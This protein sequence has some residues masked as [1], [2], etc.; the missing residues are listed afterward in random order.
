MSPAAARR[1]SPGGV[2]SS[3]G[4]PGS[5]RD[6]ALNPP[7]TAAEHIEEKDSDCN[8]QKGVNQIASWHGEVEKI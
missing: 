8:E 3:G 7:A 6:R 5:L 1:S 2:S 4:R